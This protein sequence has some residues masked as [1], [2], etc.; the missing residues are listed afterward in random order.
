MST[1]KQE[2][3]IREVF[4]AQ[5]L[6]GAIGDFERVVEGDFVIARPNPAPH[7]AASRDCFASA[8]NSSMTAA[9]S[10]ARFWY[11]RI[12]ASSNSVNERD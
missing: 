1:D 3:H 7:S 4:V 5:Y 12:E 2:W 9:V 8:I 6:H 10:I 11:S